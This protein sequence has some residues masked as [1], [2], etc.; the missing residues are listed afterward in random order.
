VAA[1][2]APDVVVKDAAVADDYFAPE[3]LVDAVAANCGTC[4]RLRVLALDSVPAPVARVLPA[5]ETILAQIEHYRFRSDL[6]WARV[7]VELSAPA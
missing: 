5:D 2:A 6:P 1:D 4:F 7:D 3:Q